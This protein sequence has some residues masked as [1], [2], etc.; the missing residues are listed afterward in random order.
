MRKL[1]MGICVLFTLN[2]YSQYDDLYYTADDYVALTESDTIIEETDTYITNN[3]YSEYP[4]YTSRIN[5][6]YNNL[7]YVS[8]WSFSNIFWS[9]Y[10]YPYNNWYSS[11]WYNPYWYG[12]YGGY[13]GWNYNNNWWYSNHNHHNHHNWHNNRH[14]ANNSYYGPRYRKSNGNK[15]VKTVRPITKHHTPHKV[16]TNKQVKTITHVKPK[17]V[18][19]NVVR[20]YNKPKPSNAIVI[21]IIIGQI[22]L[23]IIM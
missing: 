15:N 19:T 7:F 18:K 14:Y 6:F 3:Y 8:Y 22:L 13:Y 12:G 23:N 21:I 5:R 2:S 11:Y 4:D 10:Y 17:T 9:S 1:L 16:A 20:N